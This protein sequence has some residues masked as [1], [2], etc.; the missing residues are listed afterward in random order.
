MIAAK[1]PNAQ[2]GVDFIDIRETDRTAFDELMF[3][4][5]LLSKLHNGT[6]KAIDVVNEATSLPALRNGLY[7]S[8]I[9]MTTASYAMF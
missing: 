9:Q 6:I 8:T 4:W 7:A 5:K 3:Y 1:A 2:P